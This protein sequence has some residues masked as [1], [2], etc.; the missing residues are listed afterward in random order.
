MAEAYSEL[1]ASQASEA[2][3]RPPGSQASQAEPQVSASQASEA[4][5]LFV[6]DQASLFQ[7]T[8]IKHL[9][10]KGSTEQLIRGVAIASGLLTEFEKILRCFGD[11]PDVLDLVNT[12]L[13]LQKQAEH[14]GA[15]VGVVGSTGAGKSSV[16][17][18]VLDEECLVPTNS[19]RACTA[20]I[21]E[22]SWNNDEDPAK[23][24]KAEVEFIKAEDWEAE[25]RILFNDLADPNGQIPE[26]MTGPDSQAGITLAKI[27][28]VYPALGDDDFLQGTAIVDDLIRDEKVN[29]VLGITMCFYA[30]TASALLMQLQPFIDS[31]EK[32]RGDQAS[33]A[34]ATTMSTWP[35]VKVVRIYTK[36]PVLRSGLVLV[37]LPG[38]H[39]SNAARAAMA[40]DYIKKCNAIWVV[41]PITRAVDDKSAHALMGVTFQQQLQFDG[42]YSNITM[43]CSKADD[44]SVTEVTKGLQ[45]DAHYQQKLADIDTEVTESKQI[46]DKKREALNNIEHR[47]KNCESVRKLNDKRIADLASAL[48]GASKEDEVIVSPGKRSLNRPSLPKP[49]RVLRGEGLESDDSSSSDDSGSDS[50]EEI[51]IP[52]VQAKQEMDTLRKE[53]KEQKETKKSLK[54]E[55]KPLAQEVKALEKAYKG[56]LKD[57]KLKLCIEFRNSYSRSAVQTRFKNSVRELDQDDDDED[58]ADLVQDRSY[59]DELGRRLPVFCVSARAYMKLTGK[60]SQDK[61]VPGFDTEWDTEIPYLKKHALDTANEFR[62]TLCRRFLKEFLHVMRSLVLQLLIEERPL[63]LEKVLLQKELDHLAESS[64]KLKLELDAAEKVLSKS[65]GDAQKAISRKLTRGVKTAKDATEEVVAGWFKKKNEGGMAYMTFAAVCRRRGRFDKATGSIDLNED[66]VK[67]LKKAVARRWKK[68][69]DEKVPSALDVFGQTTSAHLKDFRTGV[70]N[71]TQLRRSANALRALSDLIIGYEQALGDTETRKAFIAEAQKDANRTMTPAIS[72]TMGPTYDACLQETGKGCYKRMKALVGAY[73]KDDQ[74][75][76]FDLAADAVRDGLRTM[77]TELAEKKNHEYI[78]QA[79]DTIEKMYKNLIMGTKIFAALKETRDQLRGLLDEAD[80][81]FEIAY[82]ADVEMVD[83]DDAQGG[84]TDQALGNIAIDDEPSNLEAAEG[85]RGDEASETT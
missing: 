75:Q 41:A 36:A 47:I 38:V 24:Y 20:A 28:D 31:K 68:V 22:I 73:I 15:V 2:G 12:I 10:A 17:N 27:R 37:D 54:E 42:S 6:D 32:N 67:A 66:L 16:I 82:H 50:G 45:I 9:I 71:R 23:K 84:E 72:E 85:P 33:Q 14:R 7:W 43:I 5:S 35:L 58:D 18:A 13:N 40:E 44:I 79:L 48:G 11:N 83:D 51:L 52:K 65:T 29:D 70:L 81:R 53:N 78:A 30:D 69:F 39:D 74:D 64:T 8:H 63:E 26:D 60:L 57:K 77:F 49:K 80:G 46:L 34:D 19:M 59:Y 62:S 61:E 76:M 21:T 56:T 1:L 55:R 3:S 25:L 4:S